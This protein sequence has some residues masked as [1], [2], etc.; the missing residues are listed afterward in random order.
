MKNN[1]K[2]K[3]EN[4]MKN[5]IHIAYLI[6]IISV[7]TG[8]VPL[9]KISAATVY[10]ESSRST[11]SV[12]DTVI[13]NVKI[14]AEGTT[15]NTVDGSVALKAGGNNIVAEEFSLA[16]SAFGLWPRTPSLSKDG[17]I[18]SFVGGVP[19]G[20]NIEGASL[21]KIIFMAIKCE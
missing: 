18:I 8:L 21:F 20:F 11:I 10:L 19:G 6:L 2:N 13:V 4:K 16:N 7:F 1:I 14:N 5:K 9:S 17:Q 3:L 15:I 12:G